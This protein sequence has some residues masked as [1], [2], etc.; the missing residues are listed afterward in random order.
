MGVS[1]RLCLPSSQL[2]I[3][4]FLSAFFYL[5]YFR[6]AI[7]GGGLAVCR[8]Q[9]CLFEALLQT[10]DWCREDFWM[11][12]MI[13]G[14]GVIL[15]ACRI[16]DILIRRHGRETSRELVRVGVNGRQWVPFFCLVVQCLIYLPDKSTECLYEEELGSCEL[17]S[18]CHLLSLPGSAHEKK[19][20][21]K[22][23]G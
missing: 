15:H 20:K 11:A 18:S 17:F 9:G 1:R 7:A 4:D 2:D 10:V 3:L 5:L 23:K 19:R 16:C 8:V 6:L 22:A 13:I 14:T 12:G 21:K